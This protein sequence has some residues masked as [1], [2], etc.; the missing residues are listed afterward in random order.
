MPF[1]GCV[2]QWRAAAQ[3]VRVIVGI[4]VNQS[5]VL[6]QQLSHAILITSVPGGSHAEIRAASNEMRKHLRGRGRDVLRHIPPTT[7]RIVAVAD[8]SEARHHNAAY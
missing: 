8:E 2:L 5:R 1:G 6:I 4:A 7:I 3:V